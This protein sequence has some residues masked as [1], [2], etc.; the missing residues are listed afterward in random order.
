MKKLC[1]ILW[2]IAA[3]LIFSKISSPIPAYADNFSEIYPNCGIVKEINLEKNT[4]T[5]EDYTG[6]LWE[7]SEIED[8]MIGDVCVMVIDSNGTVTIYDDLILSTR[9]CGRVA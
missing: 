7:F 4:V 6:N 3:V 2:L 5:V 9:Y 1:G 8:W